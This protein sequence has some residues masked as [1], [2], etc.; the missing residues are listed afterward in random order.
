M[1]PKPERSKL[2]SEPNKI[3]A[4]RYFEKYSTGDAE[5]LMEFIG[6]EYV[7]HPQGGL[8]DMDAEERKRDEIVFFSAFSDVEAVVEDQIAEGEKVANRITMYC[9]HNGRYQSVPAT[10]K[11]VTI[12]YIDILRIK[13]GKIIEEWVEFDVN[14][15]VQQIKTDNAP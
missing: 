5:A 9:T 4:L 2:P 11:R 10:G 8:D 13:A 6:P 1:K 12:P 15:I 3:L 14:S 7:L